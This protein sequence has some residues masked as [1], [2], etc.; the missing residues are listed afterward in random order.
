MSKDVLVSSRDE[1]GQMADAFRGMI[2][3]QRA[4]AAAANAMA[5][6][7]FSQ[8][9]RPKSEWDVLGKVLRH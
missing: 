2:A 3:Y 6:G 8:S 7:D 1:I 5:R 4:M 9:V